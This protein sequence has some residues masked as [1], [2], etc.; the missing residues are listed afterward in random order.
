M[1]ASGEGGLRLSA[2]LMAVA[3]VGWKLVTLQGLSFSRFF[4]TGSAFWTHNQALSA[5]QVYSSW[6]QH[7][8]LA[9]QHLRLQ[10][11]GSCRHSN[12]VGQNP[13]ASQKTR[14]FGCLW[15]FRVA[16]RRLSQTRPRKPGD[17]GMAYPL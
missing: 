4:W 3:M 1:S 13:T 14:F 10:A 12:K 9:L 6:Q 8:L 17:A 11:A 7:Y 15:V 16:F 2:G 5:I